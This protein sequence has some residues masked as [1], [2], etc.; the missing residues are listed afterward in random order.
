MDPAFA[1]SLHRGSQ[2]SRCLFGYSGLFP[3]EHSARLIE[4]GEAVLS[5]AETAPAAKGR[6]GYVMV[7]AY[8]NIVRHRADV[9]GMPAWGDGCSLFVL[10]CAGQGQRVIARN[11]VLR[12]QAERLDGLLTELRGK[13]NDALKR[14]FYEEIQRTDRP[15]TRGAGLGLIEM[16]RRSGGQVQWDLDRIDEAHARFTLTLDL[17]E[18]PGAGLAVGPGFPVDQLLQHHVSLFHAG[19]W[20]P[21]VLDVLL[22]FA[23]KEVP[24]D[25]QRERARADAFGQVAERAMSIIGDAVPV[26]TVLQ[27][28]EGSRLSMGAVL[29]EAGA[30]QLSRLFAAGNE[31]TSFRSMPVD[32]GVLAMVQMPW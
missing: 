12:Q 28:T 32:D 20:S 6:L 27:E 17:G 2:R 26:M 23:A 7:E 22:G 15:G 31:R 5:G 14:R 21:A 25:E 9:A 8:Q 18:L 4:L 13:D 1:L 11:P 30:L 16:V 24:V 29:S 3:D 19:V 10:Q